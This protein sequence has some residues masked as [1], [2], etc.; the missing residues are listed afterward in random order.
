MDLRGSVFLVPKTP[1]SRTRSLIDVF[2]YLD[3]R[4]YLADY[5]AAKK[6]RGFSYRAFSKTA[7]LG[8]PNY[9][10][11]V[12][13]GKRNL[14]PTMAARF[15]QTCGLRGDAANYFKQLVEFNQAATNE[16]RN[17]SY[18][19]LS[20]FERYRRGQKL[21]LAQAAYH[22]HYYLPAIRELV[23][24]PHFKE[25]AQWIAS[26][27]RPPIKPAEAKEAIEALLSLGLLERD[28][29][30]R[31]RQASAVVSTGPETQ[32]MHIANYHAQMMQQA[33]ASMESVRAPQRDISSITTCV[34]PQGLTRLK[35]RIQEFRRELIELAEAESDKIQVVQINFQLFPLS[36]SIAPVAPPKKSSSKEPN[37]A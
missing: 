13:E 28:D 7:G 12:I 32:G 23:A 35:E 30:G 4:S 19:R 17:A 3:Y 29:V 34:G 10:K 16:E 26:V 18:A 20:A 8:A 27:L 22:S 33:I 25:D 37:D 14:T 36:E 2:R 11:L 9:L 5:Y 21:E 31:L 24:S 15:A 1:P 6:Q